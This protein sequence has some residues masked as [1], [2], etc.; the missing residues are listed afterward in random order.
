MPYDRER[1][2]LIR[3]ANA[4]KDND[5]SEANGN[6]VAFALERIADWSEAASQIWGP[7]RPTRE[8]N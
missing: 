6:R 7:M 8:N 1:A 4:L 5:E 3:I 2:A